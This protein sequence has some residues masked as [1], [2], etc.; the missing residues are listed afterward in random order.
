ML[1]DKGGLESGAIVWDAVGWVQSSFG[2]AS[3]CVDG[4]SYSFG[5]GG[6]SSEPIGDYIARNS[7]RSGT[8]YDF[9]LSED[10]KDALALCLPRIST[11]YNWLTY[12]CVDLIRQ[13]LAEF[14]VNLVGPIIAPSDLDQILRTRDASE[15]AHSQ[16]IPAGRISLP[17]TVLK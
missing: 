3:A 1:T 8:G 13:R 16:S 4:T 7:F 12:I 17:W 11:E 9:D 10:Q 15:H 2:H 5:P 6:M 14:Y